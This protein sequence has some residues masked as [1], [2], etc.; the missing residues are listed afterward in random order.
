[1]AE[2]KSEVK[3]IYAPQERVYARYADLSSLAAIQQ[4]VDNP[5]VRQRILEQAAGKATPEQVDKVAEKI[6]EMRFDRDSV[7]AGSPIGEITLR[8]VER[9][10]PKTVKFVLEGVPMEANLWLQLLPAGE[11]ECA[12]RLT[13]RA[14]LNFL[15]KQMLGGKLQ[16]GVDGL[17]QML[18]GIP[19]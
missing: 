14:E 11:S 5:E 16:K 12:M 15:M 17:A 10:E 1:M 6:K 3:K 8:I 4:H 19:Y 2:Y 7:T 18:A 13:L 9:E